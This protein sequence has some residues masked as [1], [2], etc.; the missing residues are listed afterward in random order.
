VRLR[1]R[2][3][4]R[5]V[6]DLMDAGAPR[7]S[8]GDPVSAAASWLR[9]DPGEIPVVVDGRLLGVVD[10][11]STARAL[12][13]GRGSDPVQSIMRRRFIAL[14]PAGPLGEIAPWLGRDGQR[15]YPVV[16]G[17]VFVGLLRVSAV[18]GAGRPRRTPRRGGWSV[19]LG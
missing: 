6:A 18:W 10:R 11:L 1:A 15:A 4:D 9:A 2:L 7:L 8:P 12:R 13:E 14:S 16:D 5:R 19:D 17:G 3:G